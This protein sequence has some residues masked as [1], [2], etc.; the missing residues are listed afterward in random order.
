[1]D[2]IPG[3]DEASTSGRPLTVFADNGRDVFI[4]RHDLK[5]LPDL[6]DSSRN[7]GNCSGN[8]VWILQEF[9]AGPSEWKSCHGTKRIAQVH[10]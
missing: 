4:G 10:P 5:A 7:P 9:L 8:S 6:A 1:V 2:T 3:V